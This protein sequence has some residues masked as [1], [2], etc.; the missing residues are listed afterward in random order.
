[1]SLGKRIAF[2]RKKTGIS[3][4]ELANKLKVSPSSVAMW[5]TDQRALKDDTLVR[6]ADFFNVPTDYLLGR[7]NENSFIPE[8]LAFDNLEGLTDEDLQK[9][10]E[11]ISIIKRHREEID[12]IEKEFQGDE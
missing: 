3:Q 1:M 6:L 5:E 11:Y 2:L 8:S 7:E 4:T 12:K 9:V 10:N